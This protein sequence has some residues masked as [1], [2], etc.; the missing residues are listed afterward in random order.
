MSRP[1]HG[2]GLLAALVLAASAAG[3]G[4][5]DLVHERDAHRAAAPA[6]AGHVAARP[7]QAPVPV[8]LR[9]SF[10]RAGAF[11]RAVNLS[12][13]DFPGSH[14]TPRNASLEN[15]QEEAPGCSH[16]AALPLGGG[17]SP[18]LERGSALE[19]ESISSSVIVMPSAGAARSDL[20][21]TDSS[22][23]LACYSKLL[24]RKLA[25]ESSSRVHIGHI[26]VGRLNTGSPLGVPTYGLRI[27]A[28][29]SAGASG[30]TIGLYVDAIAF[31][32]GPAEIQLYA[33]SFVQPVAVRTENEL[34]ELMLARARLA[35]L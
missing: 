21:Y 20:A 31:D 17:R 22:A 12:A 15:Q 6:S 9:L 14:L 5:S 29:I 2:A 16:G 11:A 34:L 8:P 18:K 32:Y 10:A 33:T 13:V 23:G 28:D 26:S 24:S 4:K 27:R 30:V 25:G 1:E 3:C 7:R 35:R 19:T